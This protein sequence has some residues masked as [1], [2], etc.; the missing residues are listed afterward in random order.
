MRVKI[1]HASM[2]SVSKPPFKI[3][4]EMLCL[5][6]QTGLFFSH[7]VAS[8]KPFFILSC[9]V[10]HLILS[11][12]KQTVPGGGERLHCPWARLEAAMRRW[13][14]YGTDKLWKEEQLGFLRWL[15]NKNWY[16]WDVRNYVT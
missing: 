3:P 4:S 11:V 14:P 12:L 8:S 16:L 7:R 15:T 6:P 5:G 9:I 10:H 1:W 13:L 2:V